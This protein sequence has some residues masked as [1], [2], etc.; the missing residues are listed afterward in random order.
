MSEW[1]DLTPLFNPKSVAVVGATSNPKRVGGRPIPFLKNFGFPGPIHPVNPRYD[2]LDGDCCFPRV[3]DIPDCPD[4]AILAVPAALCLDAVRDCQ[5]AGVPAIT[6][7]TS[8]FGET[9]DEGKALQAEL[10]ALAKSKGTLICGPNCQGIAN[11]HDHA[12]SNFTSALASG[13]MEAG[14]VGFASQSGLFGGI[15]VAEFRRRG[16][17]L[18][19]LVST[20]NE[21]DVDFAEAFAYMAADPRIRVVAGY[22]EGARDG[23]KLR[24]AAAVARAH[25]KPIVLIKVGR[26]ADGARTASAHTGATAGDYEVYR[27][28]LEQ[29][30]IVEV[31]TIQ[32]LFDVMETFGHGTPAAK[33]NRIGI[34]SNSGGIGVFCADKVTEQGLRLSEFS[35]VTTAGILESLPAFGSPANPVDFTLQAFTDPHS[36]GS[37][38]R[39][40]VQDDGV[41]VALA[42]F[43][44]QMLNADELVQ[45]LVEANTL[46]DTPL[47]VGWMLGASEVPGRLRKEGI[48]CFEDPLAAIT[49]AA[50]LARQGQF[51]TIPSDERMPEPIDP[52]AGLSE[53]AICDLLGLGDIGSDEGNYA[54]GFV[55]STVF[56]AMVWLANISEGSRNLKVAPLSQH[57]AEGLA[58]EQWLV[59][60]L[61]TLSDLAMARLDVDSITIDLSANGVVVKM[62]SSDDAREIH[63]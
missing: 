9:G 43:G 50:A 24:R 20:G 23:S 48:P 11:F 62:P 33:G 58:P 3:S 16:M 32:E 22:V 27:A 13:G 15:V 34:A 63:P 49:A 40:I 61:L 39:N 25:G 14:P 21:A 12:V 38:I 31:N 19:Y 4:M 53:Q 45:E 54:L 41:D 37:H 6:V 35:P 36:V 30:G 51:L 1:R 28:A 56:G 46:N 59:D 44:V 57:D 42:F 26:S 7:Y 29:W 2:E 8:G 47:L 60:A 55:R 17:G 52:G 10:T 5:A 18:G